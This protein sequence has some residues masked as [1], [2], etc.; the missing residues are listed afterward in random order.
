MNVRFTKLLNFARIFYGT[1][2]EP[3]SYIEKMFYYRRGGMSAVRLKLKT[4]RV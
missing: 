1:M 4:L 3:M 2:N